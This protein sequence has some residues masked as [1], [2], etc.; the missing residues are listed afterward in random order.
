LSCVRFF[1]ILK[2]NSQNDGKLVL[3]PDVINAI[4]ETHDKGAFMEPYITIREASEVTKFAVATL[5]KYVLKR[6]IPYYKVMG[7]I[8][9]R[10]SELDKWVASGGNRM[11]DGPEGDS[12]GAGD[13]GQR[14][15]PLEG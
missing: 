3:T 1:I 5:R 11:A 6:Q 8:R 15:L 2:N 13:D 7:A 14:E 9:F 10:K 4:L 12:T